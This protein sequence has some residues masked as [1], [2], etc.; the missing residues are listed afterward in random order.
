MPSA[1]VMTR[2]SRMPVLVWSKKEIWRRPTWRWTLRRISVIE[3]W[4]ARPRTWESAKPVMAWIRVAPPAARTIQTSSSRWP[5]PMT[6]SSRTLVVPGSTR[7]AMRE[8]SS[9]PRPSARRPLRAW[10]SSAASRRIT[11]RGM[12]FFFFFS[13]SGWGATRERRFSPRAERDE[14]PPPNSPIFAMGSG[15]SENA[16]SREGGHGPNSIGRAFALRD[17]SS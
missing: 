15:L 16:T 1:S 13:S 10:T 12:D 6:L 2:D 11:E 4:A 17:G 7:P 3:C 14:R 8:I 9:R 5:L